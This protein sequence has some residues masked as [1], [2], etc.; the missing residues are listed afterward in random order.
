MRLQGAL[1]LAFALIVAPLSCAQVTK[2]KD[3]QL[4]SRRDRRVLF[5]MAT[6][7]AGDILSF[8]ARDTGEWELYRVS[9]WLS[10][11][12]IVERLAVPGFF[13]KKD[14]N[15][16]GRAMEM[17]G[18]SIFVT[19][20]GKYAICVGS[21]EWLKRVNGWAIGHATSDDAIAVVD[22]S[23]FRIVAT[24]HTE[25]LNLFEF[26]EVTLDDDGYIRVGSLSSG[27]DRHGAFVRLSIP[28]LKVSPTCA[29]DWA[30]ESPGRQHPRPTTVK[31]CSDILRQQ[32]LA[33]YLKVKE[34]DSVV[35][36]RVCSNNDSEF[37]QVPGEFTA[38][39]K[40]GIG[41]RCE[42]HDNFFGS[43]VTTSN[44]YIIFSTSRGTDI[45][46]I[47]EP[48]NDSFQKSLISVEGEDYLLVLQSGTHVMVYRLQD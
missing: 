43:W 36:S 22:L 9:G 7:P 29:Y 26:H 1:S 4:D 2:V 30:E 24:T 44:S 48:T 18:P 10:E 40:F 32:S 17:M 19:R 46:E 3:F 25:G 35:R 11:K 20:D 41:I 34:T 23:T 39:G 45:S 15:R 21:A 5:S 28:S 14:S 37:C 42:G 38:D 13:S 27:K 33:D 31:E 6:T 12:P 16:D 47:K 8:V